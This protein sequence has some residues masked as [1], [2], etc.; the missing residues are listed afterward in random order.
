MERPYGKLQQRRCLHGELRCR[1]C[2]PSSRLLP[3]PLRRSWCFCSPR[4]SPSGARSSL[5]ESRIRDSHPASAESSR[6]HSSSAP[7]KAGL[8]KPNLMRHRRHP[9]AGA[10]TAA[11]QTSASRCIPSRGNPMRA[12]AA[13]L[14]HSHSHPPQTASGRRPLPLPHRKRSPTRL[15][16]WRWCCSP[17]V[18]HC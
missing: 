4:S 12:M 6:H 14:S 9:G 2:C 8:S 5:R 7:P 17:W 13:C 11:L 15:P 3:V 16:S 1:T 10:A 18:S